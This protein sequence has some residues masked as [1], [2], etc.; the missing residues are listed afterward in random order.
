MHIVLRKTLKSISFEHLCSS[1]ERGDSEY[2]T[3][4]GV[5]R[6]IENLGTS[7]IIVGQE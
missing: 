7:C 4:L 6:I 5:E 2:E 1:S 3:E